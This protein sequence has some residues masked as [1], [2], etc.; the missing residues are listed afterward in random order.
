MCFVCVDGGCEKCV[1]DVIGDWFRV[2]A[3]G[4]RGETRGGR[5]DRD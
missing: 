3:R 2:K 1:R 4:A 5:G